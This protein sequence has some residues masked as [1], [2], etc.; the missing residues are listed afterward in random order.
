MAELYPPGSRGERLRAELS[1]QGF[2]IGG[3]PASGRWV[4]Y[5]VPENLPC[6]SRTRVDWREDRR[7]RIS[8]LTAQ[9]N[10]CT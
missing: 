3:D 1:A 6:Y 4:A 7:G 5:D 10:S 9:R 8:I 2:T